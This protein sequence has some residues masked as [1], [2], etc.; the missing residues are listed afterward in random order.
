MN[1]DFTLDRVPPPV[2]NRVRY[3]VHPA[4]SP[5]GARNPGAVTAGQ[6]GFGTGFEYDEWHAGESKLARKCADT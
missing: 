6:T 5:L 1:R 3:P 4:C 2:P